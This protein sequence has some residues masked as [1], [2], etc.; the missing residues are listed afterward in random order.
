MTVNTVVC[1]GM[2]G[3]IHSGQG[4]GNCNGNSTSNYIALAYNGLLGIIGGSRVE[5]TE[6]QRREDEDLYRERPRR[7][8]KF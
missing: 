4:A 7:M 1:T 2:L 3:N 5:L 6:S 8:R